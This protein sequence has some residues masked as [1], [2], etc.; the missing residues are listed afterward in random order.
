LRRWVTRREVASELEEVDVV[1]IEE[2]V[3]GGRSWR[4]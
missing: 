1:D 2:V 4:G 3:I